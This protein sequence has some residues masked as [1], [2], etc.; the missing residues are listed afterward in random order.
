MF[1]DYSRFGFSVSGWIH[2]AHLFVISHI[3]LVSLLDSQGDWILVF[4]VMARNYVGS[5]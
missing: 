1:I 4:A 3:F 2:S 5:H